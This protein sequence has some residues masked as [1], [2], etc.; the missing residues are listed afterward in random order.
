M[1]ARVNQ[2]WTVPSVCWYQ[3]YKATGTS[4]T[5]ASFVVAGITAPAVAV[6]IVAPSAASGADAGNVTTWQVVGSQKEPASKLGIGTDVWTRWRSGEVPT[7]PGNMYAMRVCANGPGM[8]QPYKRDDA[9][10]QAFDGHGNAQ[11]FDLNFVVF[12]DNDG[13]RVTLAKRT[14]GVGDLKD[15]FFSTRWAHT[16]TAGGSSVAAADVFAAGAAGDWNLTFAWSVHEGGPG[17][18]Q[19]GPTKLTMAAYQTAGFGLHGV[20][21]SPGEA[22]VKAGSQYAIA[23]AIHNP[24][25]DSDGFNPGVSDDG[26]SGGNGVQWDDK[27]QDWVPHVGVTLCMTIMEYA[28]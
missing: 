17:G 3:K 4:V 27:A 1:M 10:G 6:A 2:E 26:Y 16:F 22:P 25:P 5:G 11:P 21:F 19:I 9:G 24:P 15:N 8:L 23:F 12:G 18:P 13:T 14:V 7:T 20:S 28:V